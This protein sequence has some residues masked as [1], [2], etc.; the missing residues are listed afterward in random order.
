MNCKS[1]H[2]FSGVIFDNNKVLQ[3]YIKIFLRKKIE[4]KV[5]WKPLHL[6]KIYKKSLKTNMKNTNYVWDK[7]FTLPSGTSLSFSTVKRISRYFNNIKK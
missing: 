1:T 5:F 3:E 7:I 6:Q 2:W 4:A